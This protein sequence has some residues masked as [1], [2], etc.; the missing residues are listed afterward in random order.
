MTIRTLLAALLV[1]STSACSPPDPEPID[2]GVD[3]PAPPQRTEL[4]TTK[5]IANPDLDVLF[6][7]DDSPS[8]IDKQV[9]LKAAFPALIAQLS[10]V[11]GGLPNLHLGVISTDMGTKGSAVAT[12]G[13]T[14]GSGPGACMGTGKNGR[15]LKGTSS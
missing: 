2:A 4:F 11:N 9:A 12:P 6:V 15:L 8:M 10:A 5:A 7:I 14:I 13:P 1:S 3:T